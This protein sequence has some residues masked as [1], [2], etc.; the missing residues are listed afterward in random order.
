MGSSSGG[1]PPPP[2]HARLLAVSIDGRLAALAA[3]GE[4]PV[5]E[6]HAL[7]QGLR[8]LGVDSRVVSGDEPERVAVLGHPQF[9]AR[10]APLEKLALVRRLRAEGRKVLYVG[11]GINDAAAMAESHAA[12]A[13]DTGAPLAREC[14]HGAIRADAVPRLPELL[15][16]ARAARRLAKTNLAYAAA[17]NLAGITVA[18]AGWLH[19]VFAAL[20]MTCSSLMVVWRAAAFLAPDLEGTP[21]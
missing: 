11:D 5:E 14:A 13:V 10:L 8:E 1:R 15:R 21:A 20:V 12:L 4:S 16:I 7:W 17:Y 18:A 9:E 3:I 6:L 19:P 2:A